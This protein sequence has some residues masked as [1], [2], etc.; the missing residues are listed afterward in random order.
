MDYLRIITLMCM[1]FMPRA[2]IKMWRKLG[3][4]DALWVKKLDGVNPD[5][6]PV[7]QEVKMQSPL[8]PK[9]ELS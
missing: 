8:F 6:M 1:P 9:V 3:F 4:K 7:G 2:A 5:L